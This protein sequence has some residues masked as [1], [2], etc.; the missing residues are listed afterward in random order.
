MKRAR[1][2][3]NIFRIR[4]FPT[5]V[6]SLMTLMIQLSFG[7][8]TTGAVETVKEVARETSVAVEGAGA[9]TADTAR[10]LWHRIDEARLKNRTPDE[11]VAWVIM[12]VLVGAVAGMMT[13]LKSTGFGKFGRLMFG[14]AGAFLGGIIVHV[15][16][17]DFGWGPVLIRYEELV[18]SLVGAIV[19]VVAGRVVRGAMKKKSPPQ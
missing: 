12:G 16:R 6:I 13:S 9:A 14:L 18:F 10:S 1:P 11:L 5:L 17:F 3:L 4:I 15:G 7:A 2:I 19:L 8:E